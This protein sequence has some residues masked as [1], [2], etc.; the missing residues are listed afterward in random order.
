MKNLS[1]ETT[2]DERVVFFYLIF[3]GKQHQREGKYYVSE[4][5][6]TKFRNPTVPAKRYMC[7]SAGDGDIQHLVTSSISENPELKRN[8]Y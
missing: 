5:E 6:H 4:S 1:L 2:E 3:Y 7:K 8:T